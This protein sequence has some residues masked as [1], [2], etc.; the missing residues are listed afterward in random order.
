MQTIYST[1]NKIIEGMLVLIFSLL[2][3]D[4]VWQVASRYIIGQS[5]SFTEEFARFSLIWL[6]VLGAA[7][8]NGQPEG[9]LSMDFLL[10]KLPPKRQYKRHRVI[11]LIMAVFALLV[12][13]IGGGN[14]V[15]ITLKLGQVSPALL[16]P[17]G[18]VYAI[19]PLCGLVIIF[20]SIYHIKITFNPSHH[21]H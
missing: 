2:V 8:I 14:L 19:V 5:S 13:V 7:Y 15:Y 17:L 1:L 11:Q 3:L 9:H 16:L 4:V 6:T 20:F 10:G 21:E 12:M 18:Y